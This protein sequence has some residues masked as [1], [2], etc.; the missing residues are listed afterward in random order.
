[1]KKLASLLAQLEGKKSQAKIGE[2]RELL[3]HTR[4]LMAKRRLGKAT[5]EEDDAIGEFL[6]LVEKQ[7]AVL[8]ARD[9]KRKAKKPSAV[10]FVD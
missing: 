1:M 7:V 3:K 6:V 10:A 9:Q 8:V 5:S 2:I 4:N